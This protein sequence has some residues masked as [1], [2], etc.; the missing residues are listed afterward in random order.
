MPR[1][2]TSR[3]ST[4]ASMWRRRERI[5]G[6]AVVDEF[7]FEP[8]AVEAEHNF[9]SS[10]SADTRYPYFTRLVSSSSSNIRMR[11]ASSAAVPPVL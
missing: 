9:G 2:P 6:A 7:D 1:P 10:G 8:A 11:G 5:E 4:G 3:V